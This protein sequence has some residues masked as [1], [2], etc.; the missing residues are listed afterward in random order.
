M[1]VHS[2]NISFAGTFA[3]SGSRIPD[4]KIEK[5]SEYLVDLYKTAACWQ[6]CSGTIELLNYLKM[7]QQL[8]T[9]NLSKPPFVLGIMSNFD[10]R[11]DALLRNMKINHFF[12]FI[13]NSYESKMEKPNP[14]FFHLAI[15][16]ADIEDLR[17][18]ECLHI[19]DGPTTDY[20]GAKNAGWNA[21][22]IH[23]KDVKYLIEKYGEKIDEFYCFSSLFDFHKKLANNVIIW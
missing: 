13:L 19:G 17:P 3:E 1:N 18:D 15:K 2:F 11:L 7:Q 5:L 12:D 21:A 9:K 8:G 14:E 10:P 22:L 4:D 16:A 23:E 6:S 20:L